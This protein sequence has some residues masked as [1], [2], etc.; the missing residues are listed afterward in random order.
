[1]DDIV[2]RKID[3]NEPFSALV[4][5]TIV[6]PF[7]GKL[8]LFKVMSGKLTKDMSVYNPNKEQMEKLGGLFVLRG[9]E[10]ID[11]DEIVAGDIGATSKLQYTLTGNTLCDR[12]NVIKFE[13]ISYPQ[14]TLFKSVEPKAKGDEEKIGTS[15][16]RL[17][18]EDPTFSLERNSETK[19]LLIGGQGNMQLT[20]ITDKLRNNFGVDIVLS[21]PKIAYRETIKGRSDVQG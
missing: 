17:T 14:P 2:E 9:K 8:S 18:D 4:F 12:D 15:L 10:Q 19:Q 21:T 13:S 16:Q 7:V 5:K 20:V 1:G 11:V 6:D 3:V